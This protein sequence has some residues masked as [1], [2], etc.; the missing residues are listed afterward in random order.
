MK[1]YPEETREPLWCKGVTP[2]TTRHI[3]RS[4]VSTDLEDECP[5]P[6]EPCGLV[7]RA[8]VLDSCKQHPPK[9]CKTIR[10]GHMA[11]NCPGVRPDGGQNPTKNL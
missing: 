9:A 11:R 5:C 4:W 8:K 7:D 2:E 6:Q 10:Q 3:G 1:N